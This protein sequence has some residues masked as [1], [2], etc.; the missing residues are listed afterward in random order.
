MTKIFK[1]LELMLAVLAGIALL[2]MMVLS[3]F[4][5]VGRYGF[6]NSI[7]GTAEY[8]EMLMVV[9]I[10]AGVAF[11]TAGDIHIKVEILEP[12]VKRHFPN[13]QRWVV[14]I[15]SAFMYSLIAWELTRQAIDSF[16]S[17]KRTPV[18]DH[19]QWYMPAT[20]AAFSIVGVVLFVVA[21]IATRGHPSS[22]GE[23]EH[24]D[25]TDD[26]DPAIGVE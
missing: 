15:F 8:V 16:E 22:I 25:H 24:F 3:F 14:L 19:P 4:D 12:W 5:V 20:A 7:F 21:I 18:L 11:V 1:R 26:D 10:F 9:T 2:A 23:I 17:G 6:N 13:A